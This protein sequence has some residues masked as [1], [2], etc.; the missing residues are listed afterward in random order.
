MKI[1]ISLISSR[2]KSLFGC[3]RKINIKDDQEIINGH[4]VDSAFKKWDREIG[5]RGYTIRDMNHPTMLTDITNIKLLYGNYKSSQKLRSAIR[6]FDRSSTVLS[7]RLLILS[8]MMLIF[9][10]IMTI[11]VLVQVW[12]QI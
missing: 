9:T 1:G 6:R 2:L 12:I 8:V 7:R 4:D 3:R 10:I 5:S 11:L